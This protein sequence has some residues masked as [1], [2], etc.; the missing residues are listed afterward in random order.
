MKDYRMSIRKI[1]RPEAGLYLWGLAE[2][3]WSHLTE[4]GLCSRLERIQPKSMEKMIIPGERRL[5][6]FVLCGALRVAGEQSELRVEQ[7]EALEVAPATVLHVRNPSART[8][9]YLLINAPLA[10]Q[11]SLCLEPGCTDAIIRAA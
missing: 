1:E 6:L 9:Q 7:G 8:V 11:Q 10:A 2:E 4:S 3:G 5:F